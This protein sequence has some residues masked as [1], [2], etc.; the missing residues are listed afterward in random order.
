MRVLGPIL[1]DP[2]V[3]RLAA[4]AA[5]ALVLAL[6]SAWAFGLDL[7]QLKEAWR[8]LEQWLIAHPALLVLAL[9][10]LPGLPVPSSALL[11]A[12]GVVWRDHPALACS[13]AVSALALNMVWTYAFAAGPGRRL[14]ERLLAR[15]D[16]KIPALPRN[17]HLRLILILRLTP[18]MPFFVQNYALGLLRPPF[19]L[20]LLVSLL[21]NAPVVCGLVLSGAGLA[22][23]NLLPLF[24]G[25]SLV[26]LAVIITHMLRKRLN[27]RNPDPV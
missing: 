24:A 12:A 13:T 18:G 20:Y 23:G 4:A 3:R 25:V 2:R 22:T 16:V 7:A 21:C 9:I 5:C 6:I 1:N 17:D 14:I 26:V 15:S 19:R 10:I 11:V 8:W 27:R